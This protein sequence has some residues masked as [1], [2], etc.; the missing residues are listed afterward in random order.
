MKNAA[1]AASGAVKRLGRNVPTANPR[2]EKAGTLAAA[3]AAGHH[4]GPPQLA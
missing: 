3:T 2:A 1:T 4:S